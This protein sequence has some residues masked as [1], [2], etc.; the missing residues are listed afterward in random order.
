MRYK[1]KSVILKQYQYMSPLEQEY[2]RVEQQLGYHQFASKKT[3]SSASHRL[4][5]HGLAQLQSAITLVTHR[6]LPRLTT[7]ILSTIL[8]RSAIETP[9]R[10]FSNELPTKLASNR[11]FYD[12]IVCKVS[13]GLANDEQ[14]ERNEDEAYQ[15]VKKGAIHPN[16]G[17]ISNGLLG[18][19]VHL[20]NGVWAAAKEYELLLNV[21]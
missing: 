21:A 12:V 7:S 13:V 6:C 9:L 10:L 17:S 2:A 5:G 4:V 15:L 3:H 1:F 11:S 19:V 14:R 18:R 16:D 20:V 8:P